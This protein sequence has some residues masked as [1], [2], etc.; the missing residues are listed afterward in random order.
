VPFLRRHLRPV[1][2]ADAR[3]LARLIQGLDGAQFEERERATK[4]LAA[5]GAAAEQALRR[6]AEVG[7]SAE[8]K[9]RAAE[10]LR[11]LAARKADRLPALRAVE[12]LE[13]IADADARKLLEEIAAGASGA[14]L[15]E[16]ARSAL[17][18]LP[19]RPAP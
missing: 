17:A 16:E 6:A 11:R 14:W 5:L 18:R 3:R 15:T 12:A 7:A 10:L 2:T 13:R 1:P 19:K 8:T 4:E 9:R